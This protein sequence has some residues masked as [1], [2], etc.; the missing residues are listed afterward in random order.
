MQ[1]YFTVLSINQQTIV[2][3]QPAQTA[4]DSTI[5]ALSPSLTAAALLYPKVLYNHY[6][7]HV[8]CVI[9]TDPEQNIVK[10]GEFIFDILSAGCKK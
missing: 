3:A 9:Q 10:E 4:F 5:R 8:K 7:L 1:F 2:S 6:H